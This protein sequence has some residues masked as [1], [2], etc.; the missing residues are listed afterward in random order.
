M[1]QIFKEAG[2]TVIYN[3]LET[4]NGL[5]REEIVEKAEVFSAGLKTLI[6]SAAPVIEKAIL[7]NLYQRVDLEFEEK[8]DYTFSDYVEDLEKGLG[9]EV[10]MEES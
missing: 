3:S 4:N 5:K 6:G 10:I 2:T 1:K 7:K 8:P 9:D